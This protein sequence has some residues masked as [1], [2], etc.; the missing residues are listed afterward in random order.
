MQIR[1]VD[2][3]GTAHAQAGEGRMLHCIYLP[4]ELRGRFAVSTVPANELGT[5][6][7]TNTLHVT[8]LTCDVSRG[9]M[10]G[11]LVIFTFF[12]VSPLI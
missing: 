9:E 4:N 1:D 6:G 8:G 11:R 2:N 3:A 5:A 10:P 7:L 12:R